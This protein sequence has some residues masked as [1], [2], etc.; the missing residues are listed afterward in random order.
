[1]NQPPIPPDAAKYLEEAAMSVATEQGFKPASEAE[2]GNWLNDNIKEIAQTAIDMQQA[3]LEK[4]LKDQERITKVFT[5][6]VWGEIRRR[7]INRAENK[8]INEALLP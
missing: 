4:V 1:M 8:A 7:P 3:L 2:M 6:R 5:A